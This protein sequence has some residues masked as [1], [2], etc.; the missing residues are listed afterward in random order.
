MQ[1][2][3]RKHCTPANEA[4]ATCKASSLEPPG[5]EP[6]AR[7]CGRGP[8]AIWASMPI[9]FV[10]LAFG[11]QVSQDDTKMHCCIIASIPF[12]IAS[13]ANARGLCVLTVNDT[14]KIIE[15]ENS[16]TDAIDSAGTNIWRK[17]NQIGS[18]AQCDMAIDRFA[19]TSRTRIPCELP[20][21]ELWPFLASYGFIN[22]SVIRTPPMIER[23]QL[24]S[25]KVKA[26][27]PP[28]RVKRFVTHLSAWSKVFHCDTQHT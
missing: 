27:D 9:H 7:W 21:R 10:R 5:A 19:T 12:A 13:E 16:S 8:G 26:V 22:T 11:T 28:L 15:K 6:H 4:V 23:R 20:V 14:T 25:L 2:C 17:S 18:L 1:F 3:V 24:K